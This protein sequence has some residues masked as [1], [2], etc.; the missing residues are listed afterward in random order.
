MVTNGSLSWLK[1]HPRVLFLA[2]LLAIDAIFLVA[3]KVHRPHAL[4]VAFLDIGQGDAVY[5]EAPNGTQ[6]LYDAGPPTGAGLAELSRLMPFYD[7]SIDVTVL[8]HP[9]MDH[10]GGYA[11]IFRRY[12]V[13]VILESGASSTN[14]VF[15]TIEQEVKTKN[16]PR[17]VAR[18][19]MRIDMGDGVSA[20]ILYPD[21]DTTNM[22]TNS[23][24]IVM[25]LS[26]GS[27]SFLFSG[28]VPQLEEEYIAYL[29]GAALRSDVLKL[30]HHGSRTSS[31]E[32]WIHAIAP[33]VAVASVGK[34]NRY[35]HP[36]KE[37]VDLLSRLGIPLLL[38]SS[39]GTIIFESDGQK[40]TRK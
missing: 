36:H 17:I 27:T 22:E 10:I 39:E 7:R 12:H 16:I 1:A 9:D 32:M 33:Q 18:R 23:A 14:G 8:S 6:L 4:I 40:V 26:Y 3:Y 19:G 25:R 15:D 20:D 24:S 28:D 35:G 11:D 37:V 5:I 34:N 30:G 29:D 2:T 21:I 13:D 38:T 31:S